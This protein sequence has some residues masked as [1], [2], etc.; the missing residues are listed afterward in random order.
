MLTRS[1]ELEHSDSLAEVHLHRGGGE[2]GSKEGHLG[3]RSEEHS[4]TRGTRRVTK[5]MKRYLG[6]SKQRSYEY[7]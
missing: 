7:D 4:R 3:E 6:P 5:L 2:L 1:Q